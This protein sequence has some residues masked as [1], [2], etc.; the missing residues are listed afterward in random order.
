MGNTCPKIDLHYKGNI[1][2]LNGNGFLDF[3]AIV[4][5]LQ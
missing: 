2:F 4:C 3:F 1:Y 5:K